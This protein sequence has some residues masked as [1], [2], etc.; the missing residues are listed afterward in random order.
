MDRLTTFT[1]NRDRLLDGDVADAYF[2]EELAD[3]KADGLLTDEHF[4]VEGTL[5]EAWASHKSF[6]PK[7]AASRRPDNPKNPTVNLQGETRRNDTHQSTT[8]PK[9]GSTRK[10]SAVRRNSAIWRIC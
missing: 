3:I 9:S 8:D 5:L 6:K 1:K 7:G 4:A 2:A 10:P